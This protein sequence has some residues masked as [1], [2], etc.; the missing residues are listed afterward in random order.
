M[1]L[2][3]PRASIGFSKLAIQQMHTAVSSG[4][5]IGKRQGGALAKLASRRHALHS[6][7]ITCTVFI[8]KEAYTLVLA[9]RHIME[10]LSY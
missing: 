9:A 3:S 4:N 7:C 5:S 8:G 10:A 2:N 1:H 6:Y